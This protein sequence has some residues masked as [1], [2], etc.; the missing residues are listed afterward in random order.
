MCNVNIKFT[1]KEWL[2]QTLTLFLP[3]KNNSLPLSCS[4]RCWRGNKAIVYGHTCTT[5]IARTW[6]GCSLVLNNASCLNTVSSMYELFLKN[7]A[8]VYISAAWNEQFICLF[9]LSWR[10]K[11]S[12]IKYDTIDE[13]RSLTQVIVLKSQKNFYI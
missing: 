13:T 11:W 4:M 10:K 7:M 8:C 5:L 9:K 12:N 2:E 3:R 6:R 1:K